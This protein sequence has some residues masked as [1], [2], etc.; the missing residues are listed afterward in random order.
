[1]NENRNEKVNN[2]TGHNFIWWRFD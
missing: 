2:K 1:M